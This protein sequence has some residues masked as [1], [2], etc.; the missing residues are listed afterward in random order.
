MDRYLLNSLY[1][2]LLCI[3][4]I[5]YRF[6]GKFNSNDYQNYFS[7]IERTR[8]ETNLM[9]RKIPK[10]IWGLN[11]NNNKSARSCQPATE[12]HSSCHSNNFIINRTEKEK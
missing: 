8:M 2:L 10:D 9:M 1:L 3:I 12:L 6:K 4:L 7:R 11:I 5:E